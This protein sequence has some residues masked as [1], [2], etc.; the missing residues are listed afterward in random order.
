M[1]HGWHF[2]A[3][4]TKDKSTPTRD[5][6]HWHVTLHT[7]DTFNEVAFFTAPLSMRFA[8][9]M[10]NPPHTHAHIP[11]HIHTPTPCPA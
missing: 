7:A 9:G 6:T 10:F 8:L 3:P 1:M 11:P 5:P 2:A 4:P